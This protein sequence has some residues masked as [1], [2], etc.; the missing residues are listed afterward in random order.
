[1][2][3]HAVQ[4]E[5]IGGDRLRLDTSAVETNIHWPTDSSLL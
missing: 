2:A 5:L 4:S 3:E 1:L